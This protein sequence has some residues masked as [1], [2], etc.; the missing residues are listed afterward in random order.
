M[1]SE[2]LLGAVMLMIF[3]AGA[4]SAAG[5]AYP[6]WEGNPVKVHPGDEGYLSLGLQNMIGEDDLLFRVEVGDSEIN[7]RTDDSEYLVPAGRDDVE[8]RLYYEIPEGAQPGDSYSVFL[9][10]VTM[11]PYVEGGIEAGVGFDNIVP[12][13]VQEEPPAEPEQEVEEP[14]DYTFLIYLLIVLVV[15]GVVVYFVMRRKK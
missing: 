7:A 2:N 8:A 1:G 3:M 14:A 15:A 4:V 9:S 11:S 6:A 13:V 5:V 12:F 10:F